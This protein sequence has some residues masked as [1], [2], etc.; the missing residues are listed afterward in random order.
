MLFNSLIVP[1][2]AL[3]AR[4]HELQLA[5]LSSSV[6]GNTESEAKPCKRPCWRSYAGSSLVEQMSGLPR[7]ELVH[8]YW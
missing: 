2:L 4:L 3:A 1:P 8:R 5:T 7:P 6:N